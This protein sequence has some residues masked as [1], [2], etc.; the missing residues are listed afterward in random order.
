M[1]TFIRLLAGRATM[2][3]AVVPS[4]K[5]RVTFALPGAGEVLATRM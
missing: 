5:S 4:S 2:V 3:C 1:F